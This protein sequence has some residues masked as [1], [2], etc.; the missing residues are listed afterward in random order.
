MFKWDERVRN[1]M[2]SEVLVTGMTIN[3]INAMQ[4]NA[5][6]CNAMQC[7]ASVHR[8]AENGECEWKLR[9]AI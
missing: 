7:N 4:C 8:I 9:G 1:Y 3:I 6:Q 5:M 2:V